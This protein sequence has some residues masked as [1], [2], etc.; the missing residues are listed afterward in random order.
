MDPVANPTPLPPETLSSDNPIEQKS[1][2][3]FFKNRKVLIATLSILALLLIATATAFSFY[4]Q[5]NKQSNSQNQTS[6]TP[7]IAP[8]FNLD[9]TPIPTNQ[10][11]NANISPT[12]SPKSDTSSTPT[13]I[14]T[15]VL[16]GAISGETR[17]S[18]YYQRPLAGIDVTASNEKFNKSTKTQENG[19][20]YISNLPIGYYTI[21]FN[22]PDYNFGNLKIQVNAGNNSIP[23][24][25]LGLLKNPQPLKISFSAFSD[26]NSNGSKDSGEQDLNATITLY[27]KSGTSWQYY[28]SF[29]ADAQGNYS[30][31]IIESGEYKFDPGSYTFYNK[32]SSQT[33]IVDG[34]GGNKT[35]S[36]AY[37]PTVSNNGLKIYVFN[38]K[39]ENSQKDV[40]EEYIHYQYA[41]IVHYTSGKSINLVIS[42]TG[43]EYRNIEIGTYNINLIPESQSWSYYYKITKG[44][45]SVNI[46]LIS[47]QQKVELG[48]HKLY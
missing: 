39:N 38:D 47:E 28:K 2:F 41:N 31:E 18:G 13:P 21:S 7:T 43:S 35:F 26:N 36:L 20:Y 8:S 40:D 17:V 42:D 16:Q 44:S 23:N 5:K 14:P 27:K 22:H 9:L 12:S 33:L 11:K 3:D 37:I 24:I 19:N 32:P 10:D 25:A 46:T 6:S 15:R 48:A 34:Y 45:Y 1:I 29:T 30:L 4:S